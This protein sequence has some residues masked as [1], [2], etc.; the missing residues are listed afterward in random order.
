MAKKSLQRT[1]H[2]ED[3]I[4]HPDFIYSESDRFERAW[5]RL[6]GIGALEVITTCAMESDSAPTSRVWADLWYFIGV[7]TEDIKRDIYEARQSR[8]NR[9]A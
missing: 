7:A 3:R 6:N 2:T 9:E 1:I 8:R 5:A 4:S